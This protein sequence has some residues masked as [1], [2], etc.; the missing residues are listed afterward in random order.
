MSTFV[1]IY[2]LEMNS[3]QHILYLQG[4]EGPA[5]RDFAC[6]LLGYTPLLK[7]LFH[8]IFHR[9]C[10]CLMRGN[11]AVEYLR[12]QY[13]D[14]RGGGETKWEGRRAGYKVKEAYRKGDEGSEK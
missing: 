5:V 3:P 11:A 14:R 9:S 8:Q 6:I 12:N 2:G 7:D 10:D 1:A 4:S 13:C